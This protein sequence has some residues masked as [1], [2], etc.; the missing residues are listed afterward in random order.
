[1]ATYLVKQ[2]VSPD[3]TSV[4]VLNPAT[5]SF[6]IKKELERLALAAHEAL[7]LRHYSRSDF[8]V[9]PHRGIYIIETNVLPGLTKESLL[10]KEIDAVGSSLTELTGHL[11]NLAL[12]N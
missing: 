2:S 7:G 9:S 3:F 4:P 1:M 5:F 6:S 11:I 10:P 12:D 8:I